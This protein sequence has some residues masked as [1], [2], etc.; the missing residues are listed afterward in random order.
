M[1][2][3]GG[4]LIAARTDLLLDQ[5]QAFL[6]GVGSGK[7]PAEPLL[8]LIDIAARRYNR[9]TRGMSIPVLSY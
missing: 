6:V 7:D 5:Q 1:D 9:Y 2:G 8:I 3:V 4:V